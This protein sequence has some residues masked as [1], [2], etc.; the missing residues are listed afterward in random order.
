MYL[1]FPS[2][3][4]F[5]VGQI[6]QSLSFSPIFGTGPKMQGGHVILGQEAFKL[7]MPPTM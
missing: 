1:L 2:L 4:S 5:F 3:E 6:A 7:A